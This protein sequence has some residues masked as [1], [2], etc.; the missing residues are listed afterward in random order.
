MVVNTDFIEF[1]IAS[2]QYAFDEMMKVSVKAEKPQTLAQK[3]N[4]EGITGVIDFFGEME[5]KVMLNFSQEIAFSFAQLFT[6][7]ENP[8]KDKIE[9]V[10]GE[11]TNII[12]GNAKN[13]LKADKILISVPKIVVD[14]K[15][16]LVPT[17]QSSSVCIPFSYQNAS[18]SLWIIMKNR[19]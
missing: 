10:T 2:C 8:K 12:A 7:E 3:V 15:F 18:F 5:G 11:L 19:S 6:H 1:F 9:D 16:N 14:K 17:P 4:L 13:H